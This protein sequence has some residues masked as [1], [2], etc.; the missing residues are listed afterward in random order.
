[1]VNTDM[2][3][4]RENNC[5][6]RNPAFSK[7]GSA[8]KVIKDGE[9]VINELRERLGLSQREFGRRIGKTG[10][11]ISQI[12][13][14]KIKPSREVAERIEKAFEPVSEEG[15]IAERLRTAR[16]KRNYS[17]EE[18]AKAAGCNRNTI[19]LA[20]TGR[21]V[22]TGAI[23]SRL[24]KVLWISEDWLRF[25][26]GK[27]ER[28]EAVAEVLEKIDSDPEVRKAVEIFLKKDG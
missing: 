10:A 20:E 1:M 15:T 8:Y 4:G 13:R 21:T 14:G 25:G 19:S 22:P 7:L 24:C 12:E 17:Q 5:S 27:M 28:S 26:S 3:A 23:I 2:D 9:K 11:Y 6:R 16:K 18:L